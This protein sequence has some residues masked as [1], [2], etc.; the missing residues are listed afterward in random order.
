MFHD[1]GKPVVCYVTDEQHAMIS[2]LKDAIRLEWQSNN[3]QQ[4]SISI[5]LLH[6]LARKV[7]VV[8]ER[9]YMFNEGLVF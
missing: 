5:R 6:S 8:Q 2:D 9:T 4:P 1:N 3:Y 7:R